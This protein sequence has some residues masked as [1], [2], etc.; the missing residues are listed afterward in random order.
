MDEQAKEEREEKG[1]SSR[2][3]RFRWLHANKRRI[4]SA[5]RH[6]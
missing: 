5:L 4:E 6:Q 1:G 2:L 3:R